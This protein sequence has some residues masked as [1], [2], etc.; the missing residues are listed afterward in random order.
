MEKLME[1][2]YFIA[3]AIR[4]SLCAMLLVSAFVACSSVAQ[5]Q[6]ELQAPRAVDQSCPLKNRPLASLSVDIRPRD[7][8]TSDADQEVAIGEVVADRELPVGCSP[9]QV[10]A[11]PFFLDY[12]KGCGWNCHDLLQLARFC[13]PRLYFEDVRVERYG[14]EPCFLG[15][16]SAAEFSCDLFFLPVRLLKYKDSPCVRTPTPHCMTGRNICGY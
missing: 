8:P 11:V 4:A 16:H 1:E 9:E 14:Y 2:R 10:A 6:E 12:G 13:H 15:L 3:R 5:A 7:V